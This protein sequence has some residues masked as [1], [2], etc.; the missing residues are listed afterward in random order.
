MHVVHARRAGGH[1]GEAGKTAIDVLDDFRRRR[2]VFFQHLLD[3]IDSAARTIE[4]IPQQ[5]VGRAGRGAEPAMHAGPQDLVGF[6]NI[7]IGE[8]RQAE[9]G[10]H[11]ADPEEAPGRAIR[12]RLRMPFGSKLRRTRSLKAATPSLAGWNTSIWRLTSSAARSSMAWPPAEA[13]HCRTNAAWA[14]GRGGIAAQ[15]RPPPQS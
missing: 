6:G 7:G 2:A 8:L 13:V 9:F 12:P 3:E 15:I 10:L 11:A 14:S 4:F 1:A 5:D